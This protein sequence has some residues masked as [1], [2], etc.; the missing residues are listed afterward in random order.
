MPQYVYDHRL[1][2]TAV[3]GH[4]D[5]DLPV[6][7]PMEA[8]ELDLW[9]RKHPEY[10][11]WCGL[12]LGGCGGE[13]SDRRY[14]TKVCHFAHHPSAP[15]CYRTANGESSA[16]HLFI[17]QGVRRLLKKRNLRGEVRT[18]DLG[19]GPGD[20]VDVHLPAARRRIRFQLSQLDYRTWRRAAE[21]LAK[22]ADDI[23]WIFAGDG[24][25]TQ[26]LLGRHGHCWRV[27]LETVGGERRVHIG[28]EARDRTVS[29]T[30]LEDCG[31]TSSGIVTPEI[32]R[33]HVSPPKPRP[34]S[35]PL[36]GSLVFALAPEAD[37]SRN[38][39]FA[40]EGRRLLVA[41]V[42]P[43]D[44]PIVRS[45]ISLPADEDPP[46]TEHVYRIAEGAARMLVTENG[47]DWAIEANRFVRLNAHDAQHT[48]LWTPPPAPRPEPAPAP[49][50]IRPARQPAPPA[51]EPLTHPELVTALRA[52]LAQQAGQGR[53]TTWEALAG[54]V[55]PELTRYFIADRCR[56]LVEVDAPLRDHVPVLS[57]IIR[58][59][60]AP[61]PYLA[62]VLA[63][64]GMPH[65]K[66]TSRLG[67]WARVE[68]K[69]AFAAYDSPPRA[70][71]PR[72]WLGPKR[73]VAR[74]SEPVAEVRSSV[75]RQTVA[76]EP[77]KAVP[78]AAEVKRVR[79]LVTELNRAMSVLDKPARKR[80]SK[81]LSAAMAWLALH[82]NKKKSAQ[83]RRL[84]EPRAHEH[85]IRSLE[86]ALRIAQDE[87]RTAERRARQE[88]DRRE[89]EALR[90][91]EPAVRPTASPRA[92]TPVA[93]P[94]ARPQDP[95]EEL[96]RRLISIAVQGRTIPA[97]TLGEGQAGV[98]LQQRLTAVDRRV[99]S[100][101]PLLSALVTGP[102]G[103]PVTFFRDILQAAGLAVPRTDEALVKIWRREQERAH[104]K[105]AIPPRPLPARLVPEASG[106][107]H[108]QG[109][110]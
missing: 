6:I 66:T 37:V 91:R 20:A 18:R 1:V 62:D 87:I 80:V 47:R 15:T 96:T 32:E 25:V 24:P 39:P 108:G 40:A 41:D 19:T 61:L 77:V 76:A 34:F 73:S 54:M 44:S 5:S 16:D 52:T 65:V 50:P 45:L 71:P 56:L 3:I 23:D 8:H 72:L 82:S 57:A 28:T 78:D 101:V 90:K 83:R 79:E 55:S 74:Q 64:L 81:P 109:E 75:I 63:G 4:K 93:L 30:P 14:T 99:T 53:T 17:K 36:Q 12:Q 7:L 59:G 110:R 35:F 2:Q 84:L 46:P 60:G 67:E 42:K 106:G 31:L 58:E 105:H 98:D 33:I 49:E 27:R 13:L 22:D 9:R 68:T 92:S 94:R 29:W 97:L 21:E 70:M 102:D 26:H 107:G 38:S 103:G 11:Y 100:D 104:A 51:P 43:V 95:V 86:Q 88:K 10:T 48:G 85:S 69:R 89:A